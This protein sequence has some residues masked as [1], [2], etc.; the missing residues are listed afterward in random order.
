MRF[1]K[2]QRGTL[3][4]DEIHQAEQ[5]IFRFVQNENFPNVSK[6]IANNNKISKTLNFAKLSPFIE[7][8]GTIRMKNRLKLSN[9]DY[10]AKHPIFLTAKHPVVQLLLEKAYRDSLHEGTEYVRNMPQQEY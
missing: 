1:N 2:K 7:E 10:N 6:S 9:F 4:A 8:G 5:I 3:K